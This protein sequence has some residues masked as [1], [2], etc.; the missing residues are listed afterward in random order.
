[1]SKER[2][3]E[4]VSDS[5]SDNQ[6]APESDTSGDSN[7]KRLTVSPVQNYD[8]FITAGAEVKGKKLT[9]LTERKGDD[10]SKDDE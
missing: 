3:T 8:D 5:G 4:P 6:S 9:H 10:S 7:G 1:M 2:N